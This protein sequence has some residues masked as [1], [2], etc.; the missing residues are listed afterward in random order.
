MNAKKTQCIFIGSH[1]YIGHIPNDIRIN[2]VNESIVPCHHV[3]NLGLYMDRYLSFDFHIEEIGKKVTGILM[4]INRIKDNFDI[5]TRIQV[6]QSL[7]LSI[8]NYCLKIWGTTNSIHIKKAQKLQNFAAKVAL[9]GARKY[10]HVTPLIKKL[11]WLKIKDKCTH[12]TCVAV[13]KILMKLY[14]EWL[15]TLRTIDQVHNVA[16]RQA[17][18]LFVERTR[19]EAG[20]RSLKIR[21]PLL[22][23]NLPKKVKDVS[24]LSIFKHKLKSYL[25]ENQWM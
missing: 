16:T 24:T 1:Q 3:K 6:V 18:N 2:C 11:Q 7:A 14:P 8:I 4:Y 20:S 15:I 13:Y 23:N 12:D 22:W 25:L 5:T 19:T 21:G 10:D 9:G 17:N